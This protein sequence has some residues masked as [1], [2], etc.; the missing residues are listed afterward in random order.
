MEN[1]GI[2]QFIS[3]RRRKHPSIRRR[4]G[5]EQK[6]QMDKIN[7]R[8]NQKKQ[9]KVLNVLIGIDVLEKL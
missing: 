2:N 4:K 3:E 5:R 7:K 1:L 6:P 8:N 9:S